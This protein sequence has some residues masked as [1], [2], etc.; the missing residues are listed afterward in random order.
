MISGRFTNN[1]EH[2]F[3]FLNVY[4]LLLS[5]ITLENILSKISNSVSEYLLDLNLYY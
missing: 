5:I 4:F 2:F 1:F 3:L